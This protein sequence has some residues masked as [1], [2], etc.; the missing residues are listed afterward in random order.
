MDG[1]RR[2]SRAAD[3]PPAPPAEALDGLL[4]PPVGLSTAAQAC[5]RDMAPRA[6]A[7]RTLIPEKV[8]GFRELCI[9]QSYVNELD[10][11][12]GH[13]GA[14]T[15]EAAPYL[16]SRRKVSALLTVSL[17]EFDLTSFGKPATAEKPK[18]AVNPFAAVGG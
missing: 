13:L 6:I 7:R 12:I 10:T 4:E 2:V 3:L 11:R 16:E 14:A 9:R 8:P 18:K 5:W 17:K 15:R 1:A